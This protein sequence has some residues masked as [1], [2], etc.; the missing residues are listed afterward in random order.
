VNIERK[1]KEAM[2]R[3]QE[4]TGMIRIAAAPPPPPFPGKDDD[5]P[6][7]GESNLVRNIPKGHPYDPKA[8]KPL[9]KMLWA[10]SV[11]MGHALT[12]YR[13]FTRLKSSS[14]SPDGLLG[15]RGYIMSVK[16][17]RKR[18][19]EACEALSAI[20]DTVHD[21][22]NADHWKPQ[23]NDLGQNDADD[24][25]KYLDEAQKVFDNPEEQAEEEADEIESASDGKDA[26]KD[27]RWGKESEEDDDGEPG[28]KLPN[29]GESTTFQ[30]QAPTLREQMQRQPK[31]ASAK[32]ANS[33]V[34]P[35]TLPGPRVEHIQ[36]EHGY[37]PY[38]SENVAELPNGDE[39]GRDEGVG[40][41]YL[42]GEQPRP[43]RVRMAVR[44]AMS[45]KQLA[46]SGLPSDNTP[47]DGLD[48]GIGY[49]AK[50]DGLNDSTAMP[51]GPSSGLP[52]DPGGKMHDKDRDAFPAKDFI[53][54]GGPTDSAMATTKLPNDGEDPVARSDYWD[55]PMGNIGNGA[56][57]GPG[58]PTAEARLP[59]D[60]GVS[61]W[62]VGTPE[63]ADPMASSGLPGDGTNSP[64]HYQ[65]SYNP[66]G[67]YQQSRGDIPF[68][69][70]PSR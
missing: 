33:S 60:T 26:A 39:W 55:G 50:G 45:G 10:M 19:Y 8:L 65:R 28:S 37:G 52:D 1:V 36:P 58:S 63:S 22:I 16:D 4:A 17:V 48:F 51:S 20:S 29:G 67:G 46:E 34:A 15:G 18:L 21:E 35:D 32:T 6:S 57:V 23:L 12:A 13:V 27:D 47:R 25:R 69:E 66:D 62:G 54:Q 11:S 38:G 40:E 61:P 7:M 31:Q 14:I 2:A 68:V 9:A 3:A 30:G 42:Y 43:D 41:D 24:V 64:Y 44:L 49:G 56:P 53:Q 59:G 70:R 5:R